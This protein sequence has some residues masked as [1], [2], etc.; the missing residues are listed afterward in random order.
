VFPTSVIRKLASSEEFF[1][2]TETFSTATAHLTAP[3]DIGAMSAAFD[4]L[5]Q[6]HPVLA[7]HIEEVDE[8]Q[9]QIVTDDL[10]HPGIWILRGNHRPATGSSGMQ[11]D[12]SVYLINLTVRAGDEDADIRLYIHHSLADGHHMMALVS[13]LFSAYTDMVCTGRIGPVTAQPAPEPVEVLLEQRGIHKQLR[14]GFERFFPAMFAYELPP[15]RSA[16]GNEFG[17]PLAVP[18][19]RG[20]LT[21]SETT[22]LVQFGR[23]NRVFVN[24]L[25]SAAVLLAE[26]RLRETPHIPI[27]FIYPVDLRLLLEPPVTATGATNPTGLA[28]YL[29]RIKPDTTIVDL[30]R[31]IGKEFQIDLSEGVIQQSQLHFT[32]EYGFEALGL[33]DMVLCTNLGRVPDVRTPLGVDVDDWRTEHFR[34]SSTVLDVYS[35]AQFS[36]QLLIE[37]HVHSPNPESSVDLILSQLR[38]LAR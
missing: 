4:A 24:N 35:V 12:Q 21:K 14:S 20:R 33:P 18:A 26:W 8:G 6:A 25:V 36:D 30:A 13:E 17:K 38:A 34:T 11:P 7:G 27:P 2:E 23:E 22:A 37:H 5:L 10:L 19:A 28:A 9:Y 29:A 16:P 3:V 1:A 32:P 15:R 31:D